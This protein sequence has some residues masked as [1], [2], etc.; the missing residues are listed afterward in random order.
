MLKQR[1]FQTKTAPVP[2]AHKGR[3]ITLKAADAKRA[4]A[5]SVIGSHA[6]EKTMSR[7]VIAAPAI[8]NIQGDGFTMERALS[9]Q[10]IRY[11][12]LYWDRVVIPGNN[13]VYIGLPDEEL[14][15]ESGVIERPRVGFKVLFGEPRLAM[16]SPRPNP[17][18]QRSL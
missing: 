1:T 18:W 7:G 6:K 8:I 3:V 9:P 10:E 4:A 12:A 14:L 2:V 17:W 15:I 16:L 13:L 5:L 11:Y